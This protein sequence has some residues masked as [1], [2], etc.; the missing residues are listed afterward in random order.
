[1]FATLLALGIMM[2]RRQT[3]AEFPDAGPGDALRELRQN[4]ALAR[5][6]EPAPPEPEEAT[7]ASLTL[8]D[9]DHLVGLHERG[10]LNDSEFAAAKTKVMNGA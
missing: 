4:R 1:M 9:I 6:G 2:L 3:A 8:A 7:G 5:A 10:A